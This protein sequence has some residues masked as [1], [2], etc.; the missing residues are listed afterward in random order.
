MPRTNVPPRPNALLPSDV[1]AKLERAVHKAVLRPSD[2]VPGGAVLISTF[3]QY[4][5]PLHQLQFQAVRALRCLMSRVVLLCFGAHAVDSLRGACVNAPAARQSDF[6]EGDYFSFSWV[7]WNVAWHALNVASCVLMVDADV[8][9]LR[10]PFTPEIAA[11]REDLLYQQ[12]H[13]GHDYA[14]FLSSTD[15]SSR[16][17]LRTDGIGNAQNPKPAHF[18][19]AM[20]SGQLFVRSQPLVERVLQVMPVSASADP[21]LEQVLVFMELLTKPS[22]F[23]ASGLPASFASKIWY[24]PTR[25]PWRSLLTYHANGLAGKGVAGN[26][27][28]KVRRMQ[29]ALT[30]AR[31]NASEGS[32]LGVAWRL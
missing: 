32:G 30:Q 19:N 29:E 9:V 31:K 24:A 26:V 13:H 7:K 17:K 8:V 15:P 20:N 27:S 28:E 4:H 12:E 18:R 14:P 22:G 3:N 23:R 11:R 2:C 16:I 6:R 5:R 10:N 25:L 21:R 1:G